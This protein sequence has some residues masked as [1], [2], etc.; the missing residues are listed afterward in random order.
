MTDDAATDPFEALNAIY[1]RYKDI[2]PPRTDPIKLTRGQFDQLRAISPPAGQQNPAA[3]LFAVDLVLVD[4]VTESTPYIEGW[5]KCLCCGE[6][7]YG[8]DEVQCAAT[9][10]AWK[11]TGLLGLLGQEVDGV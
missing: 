5:I 11:P 2:P 10:A 3:A 1:D 7:L 4:N 6:P 9:M 8:H